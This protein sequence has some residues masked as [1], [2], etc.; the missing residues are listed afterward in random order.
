[1]NRHVV[2]PYTCGPISGDDDD[3][4]GRD[5]EDEEH[6]VREGPDTRLVCKQ[7]YKVSRIVMG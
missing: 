6:N 2:L 7:W 4:E 5:D 3:D 1:V